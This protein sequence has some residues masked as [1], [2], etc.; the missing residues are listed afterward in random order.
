MTARL[1]SA[2]EV[3]EHQNNVDGAEKHLAAYRGLLSGGANPE[4]L[5]EPPKSAGSTNAALV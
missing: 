5:P 1:L 2:D 3:R 4:P